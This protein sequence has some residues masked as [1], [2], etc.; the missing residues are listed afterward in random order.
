MYVPYTY[1]YTYGKH[2]DVKNTRNRPCKHVNSSFCQNGAAVYTEM[3]LILEV[4]LCV[5]TYD[6][7]KQTITD[8]SKSKN[9]NVIIVTLSST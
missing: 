1:T 3:V 5:C 8:Q 2:P 4:L 6:D 7:T 9:R